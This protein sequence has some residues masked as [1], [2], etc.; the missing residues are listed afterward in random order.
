MPL[1]AILCTSSEPPCLAPWLE[2]RSGYLAGEKRFLVRTH[3]EKQALKTAPRKGEAWDSDYKDLVVVARRTEYWGGKDTPG[4]EPTEGASTIVVC[5]YEEP[6]IGGTLVPDVTSKYTELDIGTES[7]TVFWEDR[8][9]GTTGRLLK[10]ANGE[11]FGRKVGVVTARVHTF[12]NVRLGF[13]GTYEPPT[14][15]F[16]L[17]IELG[18]LKAVSDG[19]LT[20]P[21]L[22]GTREALTLA[23]GQ[24][25]YEGFSAQLVTGRERRLMEV[26]HELSLARDFYF[27]WEYED[28]EGNFISTQQSRVY[29]V[30]SL[31]GLW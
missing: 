19:P 26:V 22:L 13:T 17:Y 30:R 2:E 10:L 8:P 24:V 3:K 20:L 21:P 25:Q 14:I 29:P 31:A 28:R 16:P 18:N 23:A 5:Y 4:L 7:V 11:G 6:R 1:Q 27:R 12:H 15:P 9:A